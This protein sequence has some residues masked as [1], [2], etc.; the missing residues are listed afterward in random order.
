LHGRTGEFFDRLASS[1]VDSFDT[2]TDMIES[3]AQRME[4]SYKSSNGLIKKLSELDAMIDAERR[5]WSH[6]VDSTKRSELLQKSATLLGKPLTLFTDARPHTSATSQQIFEKLNNL[7]PTWRKED[8]VTGT[9]SLLKDVSKPN[10]KSI[11][12]T[13][14]RFAKNGAISPNTPTYSQ[15][16]PQESP[17]AKSLSMLDNLSFSPP[18]RSNGDASTFVS[19]PWRDS[20]NPDA[21]SLPDPKAV[22]RSAKA[23]VGVGVEAA[24][25]G[26]SPRLVARVEDYF[27]RT[28]L[29]QAQKG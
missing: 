4:S 14:S 7:S 11:M 5:Q 28:R 27:D 15:C 9:R 8:Q 6:Q 1:E 10:G 24:H 17:I 22:P 29:T 21:S 12:S 16:A 18:K 23:G 25:G 19:S 3:L 26:A 2:M 13:P 20:P